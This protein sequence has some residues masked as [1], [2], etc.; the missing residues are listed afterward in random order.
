MARI[1]RRARVGILVECGRQGLDAVV[2]RRLCALLRDHTRVDFEEE[3]LPMDNKRNLIQMCGTATATLFA[4]GCQ[5]VVI[6]WDERPAWPIVGEPLCWHRDRQD[7][8]AGF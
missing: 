8:M 2:C 6:F 5:R 3:I 7:I 1:G 4:S